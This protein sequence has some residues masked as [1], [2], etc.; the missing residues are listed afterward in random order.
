MNEY[1]DKKVTDLLRGE[2]NKMKVV[3]INELKHGMRVAHNIFRHD[4]LLAFSK[5]TVIKRVQIEAFH[6]LNLSSIMVYDEKTKIADNDINFTLQIIESAYQNVSVW[7]KEFGHDMY[8]RVSK[9]IMK[10]RRVCKYL[11]MLR[12]V[13]TYS[14]AHCIN[15]S[16]IVALMLAQ[17]EKVDDELADITYLALL[18]DIGRIK[19]KGIFEKEEK[20]TDKEFEKVRKHPELSFKLLKRA[21]FS[22]YD[23]QFVLETHEK[24]DGSGYPLQ[25]E[26]QDIS[27][28]AQLISVAE[29]YNAL[30]SYRPYRSVFDPY[31]V[32]KILESEKNKAFGEKYVDVFTETFK[33]Y[34]VGSYVE[35]NDGRI[36]RVKRISVFNNTL[37]VLDI[38]SSDTGEREETVDLKLHPNLRIIRISTKY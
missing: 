11:N 12:V 6:Y 36:G 32:V 24:Y 14:L 33:P 25:I 1:K 3:K 34:R 22:P 27:E 9:R 8:L 31:E 4:G 10:N 37:P 13:D 28:L 17:N 5:G 30:S 26:H 38:L 29:V 35:L 23:I 16:V 21:G 19:M 7:S 2:G 20:L 15:I 18:H